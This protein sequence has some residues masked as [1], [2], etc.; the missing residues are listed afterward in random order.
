MTKTLESPSTNI[1]SLLPSNDNHSLSTPV[2]TICPTMITPTT[3]II[4]S[5]NK[6]NSYQANENL[7][8]CIRQ[9]PQL[10]AVQWTKLP[11]PSPVHQDM[12]SL[13]PL[14]TTHV[15]TVVRK[16]LAQHNIGQRVF[17]R[18]VLSLSQGTVSELLSKP[19]PWSKLTEK[20]KE[21][22]RKMWTWAHSE[23][24]IL[25][26]RSISPRKGAKDTVQSK[27][28]QIL[29]EPTPSKTSRS[30][31]ASSTSSRDPS[32]SEQL[33]PMAMPP[34]SYLPPSIFPSFVPSHANNKSIKS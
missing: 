1:I 32:P 7:Q 29:T 14:D 27:V 9:G 28:V 31:S 16:I 3:Q 20:G 33:N 2:D 23:D 5:G 8:V 25:A 10:N 34:G 4:N 22:Y 6:E 21:S 18:Y 13:E 19:K 11:C 12:K 24:S 30:S 15:S 26:L 17:A